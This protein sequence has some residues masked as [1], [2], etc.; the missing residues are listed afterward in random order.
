[1]KRTCQLVPILRSTD[2]FNIVSDIEPCLGKVLQH[3]ELGIECS[4]FCTYERLYD[5]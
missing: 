1:M 5:G 2:L 3:G 4:M